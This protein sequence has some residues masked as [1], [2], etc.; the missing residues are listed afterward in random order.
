MR[1]AINRVKT[2]I[3]GG[4]PDRTPLYELLR[5]D[6]VI[7]HFADQA[8][9]VE[10]G[11]ELIF[12]VCEQALDATRPGIAF[13]KEERAEIL[14]DGR[15]K[16][17]YRWTS[18]TA[19]RQYADAGDYEQAK[20]KLL[21]AYDP[22]WSRDDKSMLQQ[23]LQSVASDRKRLGDVF[24]FPGLPNQGL[25]YLYD[26]IGLESFSYFLCDCPDII[27]ELLEMQTNFAIKFA[28]HLPDD[29]DWVAGMLGDD[30]AFKSGPLFSPAWLEEHFFPRLAR[31]IAAYHQKNI[32]IMFHSDGNLNPILDN[33]VEAGI[34]GLNPIEIMAG[35]DVGE[36]H[37]RYPHLF[38]TGGIDISELLPFGKPAAIRDAV[39][40]AIAD[41]EGRLMVGSSS[42]L[43]NVVPLNNYL[44]MRD[45]V[46][47]AVIS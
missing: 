3:D 16:K 46:L 44:A 28:E 47:D 6:A 24:L 12:K 29:N 35:M 7:S 33:L 22:A 38:M 30:I 8:L 13:P 5:N 34:D 21:D 40:K 43:N 15:E 31:V 32:K 39:K 25:T 17:I 26:E 14:P 2:V 45:A 37:R 42:E 9:T 27:S 20:R 36:I 23:V 1:G 4:I 19:H 10:N 41:A 18:W 11:S